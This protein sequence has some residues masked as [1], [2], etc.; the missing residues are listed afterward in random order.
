M[1]DYLSFNRYLR[2]RFGCKVYKVPVDC[3]FSC[4]N[5]DGSVG[6]GGCIY[7]RNSAFRPFYIS[8][9]DSL[10]EQIEKGFEIFRR[11]NAE[12]FIIYFQSRTNT[13]APLE[14]LEKLYDRALDF[15]DVVG[16]SVGTRPDCLGEDVVDLLGSYSKQGYETWIEIG[17][18]SVHPETLQ[19]VNRGHGFEEYQ[20]ALKK[21]RRYPDLKVCAHVVFGLPGEDE[22]MM[23]ETIKKLIDAGLEGIK[24]HQMQ[25]IR[26]TPLA[27]AYRRGEYEP[28]SEELYRALVNWSLKR[29]PDSVVVQRL[30]ASAPRELLIAPRW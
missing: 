18:Q 12:K 10:E 22:K 9:N 3:G 24:F 23:K 19:R 13:Y 30:Q 26:G 16:L 20:E 25:V 21:I 1:E 8:K 7:C 5:I 15:E 14:K 29:L 6:R 4:P 27:A 28:I 2:D 17:Q 11:K